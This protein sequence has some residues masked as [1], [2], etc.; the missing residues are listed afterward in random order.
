[1]RLKQH[2]SERTVPIKRAWNRGQC[3]L[4][5]GRQQLLGQCTVKQ[6]TVRCMWLRH[7]HDMP[8]T[9]PVVPAAAD[10]RCRPVADGCAAVTHS[11]MSL[12]HDV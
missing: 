11:I 12:D 2:S 10:G 4:T 9:E 5:D 6:H 7:V 8:A 3:D 1:M